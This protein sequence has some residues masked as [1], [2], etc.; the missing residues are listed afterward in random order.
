[1]KLFRLRC[2]WL[3]AL[4]LLALAATACTEYH[5][6]GAGPPGVQVAT[7]S[8]TKNPAGPKSLPQVVLQATATADNT[9]DCRPADLTPAATWA[10]AGGPLSGSLTLAN[11][12]DVTCALRGQPSLSVTDDGGS[13]FNVQVT[14]PT[15]TAPP[16]T[17]LFKKN[18]VAQVNFTWTNWCF[19]GHGT[20]RVAVTMA[21]Q[22]QPALYVPVRDASGN[23]LSTVPACVDRNQQSTL[24]VGV[25]QIVK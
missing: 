3:C 17:W 2:A 21:G 7:K 20:M 23:P 25:M 10:D 11:Y 6:I 18:T 5:T 13:I 1:M 12:W 24:V 4:F 14:S 15:P 8:T 22:L 9:L 16:H 19:G